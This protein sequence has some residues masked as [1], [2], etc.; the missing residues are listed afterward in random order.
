M[1]SDKVIL[2]IH[3]IGLILVIALINITSFGTTS[4]TDREIY[5]LSVKLNDIYNPD[6]EIRL[7]IKINKTFQV[8]AENGD[9]KTTI[10]GTLG[11]S[12]K[13]KYPLT[14]T[15][16]EWGSEKSNIT[17]TTQL[18]LELD[19]PM[20]YGP[21]SSFLYLRTVTLSKKKLGK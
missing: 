18:N 9:I 16:S 4:D 13:G 5:I 17:D 10:S 1:R 11:S 7:P 21:V 20:G 8:I 3:F 2:S 19:K 12:N 6:F 15:V 14:L